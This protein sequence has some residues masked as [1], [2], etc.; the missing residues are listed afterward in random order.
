MAV[1][2]QAA[3]LDFKAQQGAGN[4]GLNNGKA[5]QVPAEF[6]VNVGYNHDTGK[7][8]EQGNPVMLF[9]QLPF[10]IPLE[11]PEALKA[12]KVYMTPEKLEFLAMLTEQGEA[13]K[14]GETAFIGGYA[15][16]L[17]IQLRRVNHD[18]PVA[19]PAARPAIKFGVQK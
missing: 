11:T 19:D 7:I 6:W 5:D 4:V 18:K 16:G 1:S 2:N 10:G 17:L 13:L 14:P 12:K 8:D 15:E 9:I 3:L